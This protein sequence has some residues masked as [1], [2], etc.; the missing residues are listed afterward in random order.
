ASGAC[1]VQAL[2]DAGVNVALGTD[3]AAS[4]NDLDMFAELRSAALLAKH[5]A[6]DP[7]ALPAQAALEMATLGGARAL[8]LGDQIGSLTPGKWA[9]VISIDWRRPASR[10]IYHPISQ[11]AYATSSQHVR[12]VWVA[13]R[14][15]LDNGELTRL[16]GDA[17]MRNADEWAA[18]IQHDQE[19]RA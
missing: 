12:N 5:V 11:L 15:L 19:P 8:G 7:A 4:N 6:A 2:L 9:D 1:P 14:Q 3:G 10:P 16:D 18:R 13:G 17:L